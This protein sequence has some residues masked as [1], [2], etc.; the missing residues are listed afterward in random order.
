MRIIS[1]G[2]GCKVPNAFGISEAQPR[3]RCRTRTIYTTLQ[4]QTQATLCGFPARASRSAVATAPGNVVTHPDLREVWGGF[5][6]DPGCI[7]AGMGD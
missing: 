7:A 3:H 6:E 5:R 2:I 1:E 4:E